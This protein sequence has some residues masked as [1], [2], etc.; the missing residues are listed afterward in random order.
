M[1]LFFFGRGYRLYQLVDAFSARKKT[2]AVVTDDEMIFRMLADKRVTRVASDPAAFVLA[3]FGMPVEGGDLVFVTDQGEAALRA[4]IENLRGQNVAAPIVVFSPVP[5]RDLAKAYPGI[6]FRDDKEVY[7]QEVRQVVRRM[8]TRLKVE[9]VRGLVQAAPRA[10]VVLWG[11]PDPDALASAFALQRLVAGD[12]KKM[13]IAYL[14]EFTRPENREMVSVLG[15]PARKFDPGLVTP[16]TLTLTVDAQP[17]FFAAGPAIRFDVAIDHHP[18]APMNG[19]RFADV[20][21]DYGS[22]CSILTEYYAD[23]DVPLDRRVATGLFYGIKTDTANLT[24][25]VSDADV[26]A[27]RLLR[28]RVDENMLR[29][30][31]LAQIPSDLLDRFGEAISRRRTLG[32]VLFTYLG[33]VENVDGC[34][35]VADFF[36]KVSGISWAVAAAR[37]GNRLVVIFRTDGFRSH[38]G[39][40]AEHLFLEFGTAGGHRTMARAEVDLGRVAE[41]AGKGADEVEPWLLRTLARRLRGVRVSMRAP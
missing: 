15:I 17:S 40:V 22:T 4:T 1:K 29:R 34:V 11:N 8:Q 10:L 31:E 39:K 3:E 5:V 7:R 12:A 27:Y 33:E 2:I 26:A 24:R 21:P 25:N 38:A 28:D 23:T 37:Q 36:L 41:L 16:E 18:L 14:G 20:R 6:V 30:I 32:D 9:T 35:Y 19:I 13:E